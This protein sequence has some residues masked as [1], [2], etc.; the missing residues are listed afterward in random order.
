MEISSDDIQMTYCASQSSIPDIFSSAGS[1]NIQQKLRNTPDRDVHIIRNILSW[2]TVPT[3]QLSDITRLSS[4]DRQEEQVVILGTEL[5]VDLVSDWE[6]VL[7]GQCLQ[8]AERGALDLISDNLLS[9]D[10]NHRLSPH[11]N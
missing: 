1:E 5:V 4:Q 3:L 10:L 6:E 2:L 7:L 8:L 11:D 9:E